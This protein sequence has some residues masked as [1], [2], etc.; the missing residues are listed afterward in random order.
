LLGS[1]GARH[2]IDP[3]IYLGNSIDAELDGLQDPNALGDDNN[4]ID[5]EDGIIL[6][7]ILGHGQMTTITVIASAFGYLNGWIDF[8]SSGNWT[9]ADEHIFMDQPLVAG[10]NIL[11][12]YVPPTSVTGITY[13]RFRFCTVTGLSYTGQAPDGEVEDYEVVIGKP[14]KWIQLPDLS[15]LGM[16]VDATKNFASPDPPM[17]L[18]DDFECTVTG[19]LTRIEIW[20]SWFNDFKPFGGDP[21][22]V[23]FTL[24]IHEDIPAD[25]SPTGYS[26][27]GDVLWFRTFSGMEFM[28]EPEAFGLLEGWYN[29]ATGFYLFPGDTECWKYI[30]PI[31]EGEFIQEGTMDEPKVYW[32]DVQAEPLDLDPI[33]RFGWKTSQDHWNDDA[34]WTVGEEPYIGPWNELIY[35]PGHPLHP[36][37]VDLAFAIYGDESPFI[38]LDLKAMLEGP[39]NGTDMSTSLNIANLIPLNQPYSSDPSAKWHY[40]GTESVP[41]IP[42]ADVVDW[43]MIELRDAPSASGATGTTMVDEKAA[44]ILKDGSVVATDGMSLPKSYAATFANDPYI[45]IWHRNHLGILSSNPMI[46]VGLGIYSYDFTT[47]LSQAYLNGQKDLGGGIYGMFGGNG[48]P[49]KFIDNPDKNLWTTHA[50]TTG[51]LAPDYNMDIQV[52]NKDKNDIWVPNDGEGTKVPD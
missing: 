36:Q 52:D 23:I 26:M 18:A 51:Y 43:V 4:G 12:I 32:L 41:G 46:M 13:A 3:T 22:A 21:G 15:D 2:V 49:D 28:F 8:N 34:V 40:T 48:V 1:D 6:P 44:F 11:N 7:S 14:E 45:V 38:L 9:E 35:P 50:G 25:Q 39:F 5:D 17:I 24:S 30:F 27:P 37:S 20:G 33:C 29:P 31:Q 10:N 16:D 19:P 47:N 42:N